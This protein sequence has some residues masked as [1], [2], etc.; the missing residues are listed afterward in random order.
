M[1]AT[2]LVL[3]EGDAPARV[4]KWRQLVDLLAQLRDRL[5]SHTR[6][7]MMIS[8]ERL[9]AEVSRDQRRRVA[10]ALSGRGAAI[11]LFGGDD[12]DVAAPVL[13]SANLSESAWLQTIQK[14]PRAS[15]VLLRN[16]RD[17]PKIVQRALESFGPSDLALPD[18][19]TDQATGQIREL[20]ERIEAFKLAVPE[21]IP[22]KPVT[23]TGFTFETDAFGIV[24]WSEGVPVSALI[25]TAIGELA[26]AGEPGVDGHAVGAYLRRAPFRDARLSLPAGV[27][28]GE[29]RISGNP[30]FNPK[31]GRFA[32]YRGQ[33]RRPRRDEMAEPASTIARAAFP[34]D[35]LR[36][37]VHELRTPLNA[38]LGFS[39]MI[40]QQ[41]L[42]PVSHSY[43]SRAEKIR[44]DGEELLALINEID[45]ASRSDPMM[46]DRTIDDLRA[47][48]SSELA[49]VAADSDRTTSVVVK[50]DADIAVP[51]DSDG[52]LAR[53]LIRVLAALFAQI[54]ANEQLHITVYEVGHMAEIAVSRPNALLGLSTEALLDAGPMVNSGQQLGSV[55]GFGFTVRVLDAALRAKGGYLSIRP[56]EFILALP[57]EGVRD[58]NAQ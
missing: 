23:V 1:I 21:L 56:D 57:R 39:S 51:V 2:A 37:L 40:E 26:Q 11:D 42:G 46:S 47:F 27:I 44:H 19:Q 13:L 41:V 38:I 32:G 53:S 45:Q 28:G 9:Q 31:T 14:L 16:R 58:S 15:R 50:G 24:D 29:W 48:V 6:T 7:D 36:A 49:A 18:A 34:A 35:S 10:Q 33:A 4:A 17:L 12:P 22:D 3:P 30:I 55:L 43:R 52:S 25:G 54:G 20:V 8:I 5:D